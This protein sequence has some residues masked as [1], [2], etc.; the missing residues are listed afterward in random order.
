MAARIAAQ[1]EPLEGF[2]VQEM[3]EHGVEMLVGVVADRLFGPVVACGAGGTAVELTRDVAVRVAPLTE[4]DAREMVASL[5]TAPLLEGFRGAAPADVPA[6][7][8]VI[9]RV[10]AMALAHPSI[11]EMDLNPVIVLPHGAA[12]VDAR[13]GVREQPPA[14]PFADRASVEA[15]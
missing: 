7:L 4:T 12:I 13:V 10:S 6:L 2:V 1:G 8:D 3:L 15:G 14:A 9:H 5:A 11:A